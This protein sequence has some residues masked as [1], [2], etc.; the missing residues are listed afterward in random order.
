MKQLNLACT[1]RGAQKREKSHFDFSARQPFFPWSPGD[2]DISQSVFLL[3]HY[4][5]TWKAGNTWSNFKL[6]S[7]RWPRRL[8]GGTRVA[9]AGHQPE[10]GLSVAA[11]PRPFKMRVRRRDKNKAFNPFGAF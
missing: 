10:P 3:L 9:I 6:K 4:M 8:Y 2:S 1:A 5:E 11:Q 7:C